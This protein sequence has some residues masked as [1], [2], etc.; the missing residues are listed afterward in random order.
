M[1]ALMWTGCTPEYVGS[2]DCKLLDESIM[3]PAVTRENCEYCQ[4]RSCPDDA[5]GWLPC[6]EGKYVVEGCDTD[7]EC[8]HLPDARCGMHI[9][10][11]HICTTSN[12]SL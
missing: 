12:D 2:R 5:C 6:V 9:A 4:A 11:D 3:D 10:P 1:L 8:A 7:S